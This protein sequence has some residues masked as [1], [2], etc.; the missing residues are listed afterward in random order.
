MMSQPGSAVNGRR[1]ALG[2]RTRLPSRLVPARTAPPPAPPVRVQ[3]TSVSGSYRHPDAP[4]GVRAPSV[5]LH[6]RAELVVCLGE[7]VRWVDALE[8]G[9]LRTPELHDEPVLLRG[10]RAPKPPQRPVNLPEK[11]FVPALPAR[12]C[13]SACALGVSEAD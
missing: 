7:D 6:K 11:L 13:S 9:E 8:L 12:A 3:G 5:T 4:S 10:E 1:L 2:A